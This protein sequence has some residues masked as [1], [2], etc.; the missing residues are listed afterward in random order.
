[1]TDNEIR[2]ALA[3]TQGYERRADG[4]WREVGHVGSCG[5]PDYPS[6]LNACAQFE[7]TLSRDERITYRKFLYLVVLDDPNNPDNDT[8]FATPPQRCEAFL[9]VKGLWRE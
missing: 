4:F 5:I 6:D 2:E 8:T 7:A 9:R 1:M 3:E